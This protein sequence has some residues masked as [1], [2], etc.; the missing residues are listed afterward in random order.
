MK[1]VFGS[2][3]FGFTGTDLDF[4]AQVPWLEVVWFWDVDLKSV[5]GLYALKDL[6]SF[7]I[8]PKR[9]A[10]DFSHFEKLRKA[11]VV[12]KP[13]DRGLA[14]LKELEQL[15]VWHYRPKDE[16]FS[17]LSFPA[18]LVELQINWANA[19][20]LESLPSLPYLRKLEVHCCRNLECL[21]HLGAKYPRLEH[22]VIAA[23]GRL[24][25][26]EGDRIVQDLPYL[27]HAYIQG[28][29]YARAAA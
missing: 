7:G 19:R 23:C 15:H 29:Q 27:R 25:S 10:I 8:H 4:L 21:G 26:S 12:P 20:S 22:L 2:P 1:G 6:R 5:D 14:D 11:V 28:V 18:S 9:P 16:T 3:T 13:K 17:A 24:P